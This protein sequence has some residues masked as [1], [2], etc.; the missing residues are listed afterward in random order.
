MFLKI[1][2]AWQGLNSLFF[3][4]DGCSISDTTPISVVVFQWK[5]SHNSGSFIQKKC[6][7]SHHLLRYHLYLV[8]MSYSDDTTSGLIYYYFWMHT[9]KWVLKLSSR[10]KQEQISFHSWWTLIILWIQWQHL[11]TIEVVEIVGGNHHTDIF[12]LETHWSLRGVEVILQVSDMEFDY[13]L[14][15]ISVHCCVSKESTH[16]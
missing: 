5:L 10:Q 8:K 12:P 3:N 2:S 9:L 16:L 13:H 11:P 4:Q 14:A 6:S 15:S 1:N 7:L